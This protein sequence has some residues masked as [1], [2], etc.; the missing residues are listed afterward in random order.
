M[1]LIDGGKLIL[2]IFNRS[3]HFNNFLDILSKFLLQ[4]S[5]LNPDVTVP[6]KKHLSSLFSGFIVFLSAKFFHVSIKLLAE[7]GFL[8]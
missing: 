6:Y 5:S 7:G 2:T 8:A 4:S 3:Q 1:S